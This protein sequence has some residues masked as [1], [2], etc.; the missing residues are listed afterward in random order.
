MQPYTIIEILPNG[1]TTPQ[2]EDDTE[3]I[4]IQD[5]A[6]TVGMLTYDVENDFT[7]LAIES[8]VNEEELNG[9]AT[10]LI[11]Q[12]YAEYLKTDTSIVVVAPAELAE[13]MKW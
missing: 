1:R 9:E 6:A 7:T 12:H 8:P 13:K 2:I 5:G 3:V 10:A 11:K 4:L